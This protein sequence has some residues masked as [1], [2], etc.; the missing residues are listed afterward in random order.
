VEWILYGRFRRGGRTAL[1][2]MLL[3]SKARAAEVRR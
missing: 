1:R 3:R 2:P